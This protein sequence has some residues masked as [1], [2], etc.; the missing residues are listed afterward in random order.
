MRTFVTATVAL[1]LALGACGGGG[2]GGGGAP[3]DSLSGWYAY[4]LAPAYLESFTA[5]LERAGDNLWFAGQEYVPDGNGWIAY[6]PAP[7]SPTRTQSTLYVVGDGHLEG[8]VRRIEDGV[9]VRSTQRRLLLAPPPAGRATWTGVVRGSPVSG[10]D[11]PAEGVD[12]NPPGTYAFVLNAWGSRSLLQVEFALSQDPPIGTGTYTV[13]ASTL[14]GGLCITERGLGTSTA[15]T[16][17]VTHWDPERMAGNWYF[18]FGDG[19]SLAGTFDVPITIH[20]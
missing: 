2:G 7:Y 12:V 13:G 18:E 6:D 20:Q 10:D 4:S 3:A 9:L 17:E 5:Q 19:G 15:G 16:V 8:V 1:S 14:Q 11:M